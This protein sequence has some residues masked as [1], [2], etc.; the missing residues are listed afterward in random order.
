MQKKKS[1]KSRVTRPARKMANFNA[2]TKHI[3]LV[4]NT[5]NKVS[6]RVTA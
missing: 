1:W 4:E 5:A 3:F 6:Q 2:T